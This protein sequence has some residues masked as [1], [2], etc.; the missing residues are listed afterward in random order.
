MLKRRNAVDERHR[1]NGPTD[2]TIRT[3]PLVLL[4]ILLT[5][6]NREESTSKFTQ[7]DVAIAHAESIDGLYERVY[8]QPARLIKETEPDAVPEK[9]VQSLLSQL[10]QRDDSGKALA[11]ALRDCSALHATTVKVPKTACGDEYNEPTVSCLRQE[12]HGQ[13]AIGQILAAKRFDL[14][15]DDV[16]DYVIADRYYCNALS[17][18]QSN[19]YFVM[20]SDGGQRFQLGYADWAVSDLLVVQHPSTRKK[21]VVEK[22]SKLYGT[23]TAIFEIQHHKLVERTCLSEDDNG[24]SACTP[25]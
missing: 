5:A 21:I 1:L 4:T 18:N 23:R 20:L 8:M 3:L 6:C 14:N 19:V 25:H 13:K 12:G 24:F 2:Q 16:P 15:D 11:E 9:V 10:D 17:A 22:S 7:E